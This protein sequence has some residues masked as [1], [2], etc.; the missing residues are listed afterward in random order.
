LPDAAFK[1]ELTQQATKA[2]VIQLP[3]ET[4]LVVAEDEAEY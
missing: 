1:G 2:K 3:T 4:L